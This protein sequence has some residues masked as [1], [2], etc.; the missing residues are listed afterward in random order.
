MRTWL[1]ANKRLWVSFEQCYG[2]VVHSNKPKTLIILRV[3]TQYSL[4]GCLICTESLIT[5]LFYRHSGS[6][7]E[8]I[9]EVRGN[10]HGGLKGKRA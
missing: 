8:S 5:V 1:L 7:I 4:C 3:P 2:L 6:V 10:H 9:T